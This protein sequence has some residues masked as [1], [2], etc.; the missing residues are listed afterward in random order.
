MG[1]YLGCV[2]AWVAGWVHVACMIANGVALISPSLS[3]VP[4]VEI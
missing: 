1:T 4:R 2:H 3:P